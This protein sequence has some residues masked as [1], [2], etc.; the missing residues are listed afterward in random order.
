MKILIAPDSYKGCLSSLE[1]A[2]AMTRGIKRVSVDID[3]VS[4]PFADGGEG[5]VEA[6]LA[7]AGGKLISTKVTGPLGNQI[8]SFYGIL[9]DGKTAVIEMAAASGLALVPK[10]SMNPLETTTYGTGQ[11]ILCALGKGCTEIIVGVGGSATNDGGTGMAQ[12]LGVVFFD[13]DG[14]ELTQGGKILNKIVSYD[15]SGLDKRIKNVNITVACDVDNPFYG[16]RGAAYVYAPQK[17]ADSKMIMSW[18]R[19]LK[20]FLQL[21]INKNHLI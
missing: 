12:A 10:D 18:T 17:G 5:T 1:V 14:K 7:G 9:E 11:L 2:N 4:I 8:D 20:I 15:D 19:V 6:M 21:Y 3:V 16:K 13:K